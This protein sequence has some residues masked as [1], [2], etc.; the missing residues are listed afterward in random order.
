[1]T[2]DN[3][4]LRKERTGKVTSNKMDRT[5]VVKVERMF[6]HPLYKKYVRRTK[7]YYVHDEKN[8]CNIGDTVRIIETRPISIWDED[9]SRAKPSIEPTAPSKAVAKP[10]SPPK[11]FVPV[12]R[13][14]L[15]PRGIGTRAGLPDVP[16]DDVPRQL[17]QLPPE[18]R[19]E[20]A[21][22]ADRADEAE[23]E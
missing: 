9:S 8:R 18:S 1:M 23:T 10:T 21:A 2:E 13:S 16:L 11:R 4:G 7:N 15:M 19:R 17:T 12:R 14:P 20:A 3:R 22:D 6:S 5:I